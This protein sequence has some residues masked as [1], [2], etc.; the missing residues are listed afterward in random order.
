MMFVLRKRLVLLFLAVAACS[1]VRSSFAATPT[2][3]EYI[4]IYNQNKGFLQD[5]ESAKKALKAKYREVSLEEF[6]GNIFE[7]FAETFGVFDQ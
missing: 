4:E 5:H 3:S 7:F 6:Q 1:P 2:A